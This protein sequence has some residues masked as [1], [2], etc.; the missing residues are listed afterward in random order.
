MITYVN[1][2]IYN[3]TPRY[4]YFVNDLTNFGKFKYL[5]LI[6][7]IC[8]YTLFLFYYKKPVYKKLGLQRP[9]N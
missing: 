3:Y 5:T 6:M 9:K 8:I 4:D 1:V 2:S 7:L